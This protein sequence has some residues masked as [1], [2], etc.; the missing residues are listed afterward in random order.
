MSSSELPH[1]SVL[2]LET[3]RAGGR[4]RVRARSQLLNEEDVDAFETPC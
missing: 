3:S 2:D 1:G 4:Q